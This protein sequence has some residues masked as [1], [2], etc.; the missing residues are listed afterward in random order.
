MIDETFKF[1]ISTLMYKIH[2][3]FREIMDEKLI[4]L[5]ESGIMHKWIGTPSPP[6]VEKIGPQVLTMEHLEIGF[7]ACF[8][9]LILSIIAFLT[10][11]RRRLVGGLIKAKN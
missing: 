6:I 2:C 9:P 11:V 3:P 8:V 10:E 7:I 5:L 4:Q 1:R